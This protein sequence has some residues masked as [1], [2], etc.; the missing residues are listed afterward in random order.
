MVCIVIVAAS[1]HDD[2]ANHPISGRELVSAEIEDAL[3]SPNHQQHLTQPLTDTQRIA[4]QKFVEQLQ[5]QG[6]L[7]QFPFAKGN[8]W[9]LPWT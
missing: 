6:N 3:Q 2:D 9:R 8:C 1:C 5:V 4:T 7:Q